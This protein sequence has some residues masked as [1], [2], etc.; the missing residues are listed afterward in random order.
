[1]KHS[2]VAGVVLLAS[3]FSQNAFAERNY[4]SIVG[5]STVYPFST[6]VAERFGKSTKFRTPKIESTGSGGGLKLFCSGVGDTTPDITNASRRIKASEIALCAKNGVK[7]VVE[8]MIGFDGIVFA[9]AASNPRTSL[10]RKDIF[11]ALAKMVPAADGS[12][13]LIANPYKTW[14][15]INPALA[16]TPITVLGPPPTSG[17]RDAFVELAMEGGCTQ[18]PFI[19]ALKKS[20]P[21][22]YKAICHGLREDGGYVEAGENDNLIVQ[23]LAASPNSYGIFGY[24]FL[25]QNEDKVQGSLVDG[26][27]PTFGNIAAGKYPI[28]RSLYFYVKKAHVG[29]IPGIEEY[30]TEFTSARAIGEDGYLADKGMIPMEEPRRRQVA[31]SVKALTPIGQ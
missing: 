26:V 11:L 31:A 8:V 4:I 29:V 10:S 16:N 25:E 30:L 2:L 1:M 17:T 28:S 7:D 20:D 24:S 22:K 19:K 23:K 15:Q 5:S 3:V 18:F 13:K 9:N 6:V 12:A 21:D 27:E 14:K